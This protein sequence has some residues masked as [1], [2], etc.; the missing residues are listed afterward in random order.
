MDAERDRLTRRLATLS[1]RRAGLRDQ[2]R[3]VTE[4]LRHVVVV[5]VREHGMSELAASRAASVSRR[6]L[7][8]WLG[9]DDWRGPKAKSK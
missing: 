8:I 9:E 1:Q 5:L 3:D 6:T 2:L 7:R 4:D